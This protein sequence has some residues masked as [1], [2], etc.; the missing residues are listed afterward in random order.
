[1]IK[2]PETISIGIGELEDPLPDY[3]RSTRYWLFAGVCENCGCGGRE[4]EIYSKKVA[5]KCESCGSLK[6]T[7]IDAE[8]YFDVS[9]VYWCNRAKF[10]TDHVGITRD[11][12][13][14]IEKVIGNFEEIEIPRWAVVIVGGVCEKKGCC[15]NHKCR[16]NA[17]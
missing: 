4:I 16:Y 1:M 3:P 13:D 15:I 2:Q 8:D 12:I 11:V 9:Y 7:L 5:L 17:I 6:Q 14:S 10:A